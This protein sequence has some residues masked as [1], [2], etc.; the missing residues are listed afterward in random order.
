MRA[1]DMPR[2][3]FDDFNNKKMFQLFQIPLRAMGQPFFEM[4]GPDGLAEDDG[5]VMRPHTLAA[6]LDWALRAPDAFV[7][8]LP[9][10]RKILPNALAG[11][12]PQSLKFAVKSAES[13]HEGLAMIFVSPAFQRR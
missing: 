1:M 8:G 12:I 6:R 3:R 4:S 13:R 7:R 5:D 9:D 11:D 2:H 10:P